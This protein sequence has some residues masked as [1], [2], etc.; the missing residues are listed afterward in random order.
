M[1]DELLGGAHLHLFIPHMVSVA[2]TLVAVVYYHSVEMWNSPRFLFLLI[3]YWFFLMIVEVRRS[4]YA[5]INE[6]FCIVV[7]NIYKGLFSNLF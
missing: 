7:I 5:H 3:P 1:S 6:L 4:I 2:G